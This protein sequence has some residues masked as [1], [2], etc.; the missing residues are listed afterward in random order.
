MVTVAAA[1]APLTTIAVAGPDRSMSNP[2]V[3][4]PS[5]TICV[6]DVFDTVARFGSCASAVAGRSET[7]SAIGE[8]SHVRRDRVPPRMWRSR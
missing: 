8:E 2:G 5:I 1:S 7:T 6:F 4:V 3:P